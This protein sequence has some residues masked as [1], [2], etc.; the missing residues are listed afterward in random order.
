V[1]K[2]TTVVDCGNTVNP[3]AATAQ[4]EGGTNM[5]LS[6]AIGEAI[7]IDKGAVQQTNF[8]DYPILKLADAPLVHDIH[9]IESGATMGG[10]GEPG[11]PPAA[12][13]LANALYAATGKRVR[14][15]PIKTQAKA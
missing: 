14:Q 10:I 4:I 2:V 11:V 15:L 5:G 1:H 12:P 3:N 7:T 8:G 6:A 9:Y 13:A